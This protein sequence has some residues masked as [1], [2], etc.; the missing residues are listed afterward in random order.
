MRG[1]RLFD[2]TDWKSKKGLHVLRCPVFTKN[3]GK[4]IVRAKKRYT[5]PQ[6]FCFPLKASAK[7]KNKVF[8]VCNEAPIFY[9]ALGFSLL[10]LCVNPALCLQSIFN[11]STCDM[12]NLCGLQTR[13]FRF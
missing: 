10:S 8:F 9:E 3:I 5:R 13:S 4:P 1:P 6:M 7:R 11:L 12:F 2:H